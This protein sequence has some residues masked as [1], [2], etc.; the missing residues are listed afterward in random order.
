MRPNDV[1]RRPISMIESSSKKS[2]LPTFSQ[3]RAASPIKEVD[4]TKAMPPA[5]AGGT[6]QRSSTVKTHTRADSRVAEPL[7]RSTTVK[8]HT[9]TE[10]RAVEPLK[11]STTV[12]QHRPESRATEPLKRSTT[13]KTHKRT[14][15]R[16]EPL[17][18]PTTVQHTRTESKAEPLNRSSTVQ[19]HRPEL[20]DL[21]R[22]TSVK[23]P[24]QSRG[25]LPS[26]GARPYSTDYETT[27]PKA[28]SKPRE[29]PP[30]EAVSRPNSTSSVPKHNQIPSNQREIPPKV[31][32]L[33][34]TTYQTHYTPSKIQHPKP[35]L[36]KPT[37]R[38]A[39]H[40]QSQIELLVLSLTHRETKRDLVE[41]TLHNSQSLGERRAVIVELEDEVSSLL[42]ERERVATILSMT[43]WISPEGPSFGGNPSDGI[44]REVLDYLAVLG[45]AFELIEQQAEP[46]EELVTAFEG[47]V[48]H[49]LNAEA[50]V[51]DVLPPAWGEGVD[52]LGVRVRV[53]RREMGGIPRWRGDDASRL[54]RILD[55]VIA[56]ITLME[57]ELEGMKTLERRLREWEKGRV[58]RAV[59]NIIADSTR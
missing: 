11:R 22:T 25:A 35:P 2:L 52:G 27:H 5:R 24:S 59:D 28:I 4:S 40:L 38:V 17:K 58:E 7:K 48:H 50:G 55:Y 31:S 53:L 6:L 54:G 21:K 14:E 41:A 44:T 43:E 29:V 39:S 8:S 33:P 13:F 42:R 23:A 34:F 18:R 30:K 3:G 37:Q 36:P 47:W 26:R 56:R 12:Q 57:R 19:H 16:A 9:R 32:K 15:S 51:V 10:S 45:R 1:K 20:T 49:V 46:F